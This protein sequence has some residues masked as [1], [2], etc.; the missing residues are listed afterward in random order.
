MKSFLITIALFIF[1]IPAFA[2]DI[3]E[4]HLQAAVDMFEE[5]DMAEMI[6]QTIDMIV[7]AQIQQNPGIAVFEDIMRSFFRKH[8]SWEKLKDSY[9]RI[10]AEAFTEEE[11]NEITA[12]YRTEVGK[13]TMRLTPVLMQKGMA[14]GEQVVFDNLPELEQLIMERMQELEGNN[15][16]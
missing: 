6:D 14:L 12:F 16:N 8:M 7:D 11:L 4:S 2:Q 10:Y 9:A 5:L 15:D 1:S 3:S 13:K